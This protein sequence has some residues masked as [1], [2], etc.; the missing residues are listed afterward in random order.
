MRK[1]A[2]EIR[3]RQNGGERITTFLLVVVGLHHPAICQRHGDGRAKNMERRLHL[4][5]V[6]HM[7]DPCHLPERAVEKDD[8][9]ILVPYIADNAIDPVCIRVKIIEAQLVPADKKDHDTDA[10]A[11]GQP[12]DMDQRIPPLTEDISPGYFH[13][14]GIHRHRKVFVNAQP[15]ILCQTYNC[16][17]SQ[18]HT[19]L[20]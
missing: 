2:E 7:F 3:S 18:G 10:D 5:P 17:D 13:R 12:K 19:I 16:F 4:E 15:I 20:L 6:D 8:I 1:E 11:D 9:A 14:D